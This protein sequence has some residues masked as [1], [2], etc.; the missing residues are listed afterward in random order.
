MSTRFEATRALFDAVTVVL[1][2]ATIFA[3]ASI[4]EHRFVPDIVPIAFAQS[5]QPIWAVEVSFFLRTIELIAGSIGM[6]SLLALALMGTRWG[7]DR[8]KT[9]GDRKR[10]PHMNLT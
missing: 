10:S 6:F 5:P 3:I 1:I 7:R 8:L 4:L 2:S 9:P